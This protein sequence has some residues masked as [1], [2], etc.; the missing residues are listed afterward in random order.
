MRNMRI[1]FILKNVLGRNS[2]VTIIIKVEITVWSSNTTNS[3]PMS[4]N[5]YLSSICAIK[6]P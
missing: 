3:L 2:P 1:G 5:M 6:I 4:P